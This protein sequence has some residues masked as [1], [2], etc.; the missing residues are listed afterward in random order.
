MEYL[1]EGGD[2]AGMQGKA[3]IFSE[4]GCALR[5]PGRTSR[6]WWGIQTP[7]EL[8]GIPHETPLETPFST[9]S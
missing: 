9:P 4:R 1:L 2:D 5:R 6:F 8:L 7:G 3:G